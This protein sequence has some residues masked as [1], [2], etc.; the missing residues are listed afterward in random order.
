MRPLYKDATTHTACY[1]NGVIDKMYVKD[2]RR[3]H[4]HEYANTQLKVFGLQPHDY[5]RNDTARVSGMRKLRLTIINRKGRTRRLTNMDELE[6]AGVA[7]GY[8]VRVVSFE[9]LTI[10]QQLKIVSTETDVL[11]GMHGNGIMWLQ[12]LPP[13]SVIIELI[14]VWYSPYARLWGHTHLHSSMKN[15]MIFKRQGEFVAFPHNVT[16]VR[17]LLTKAR[18]TLRQP[19]PELKIDGDANPQLDFLYKGCSPHC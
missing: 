2:L 13:R 17:V 1:T 15:N 7:L 3:N 9:L 6:T 16:E 11:M 5:T 10:A 19:N 4:A 14:G 8:D 12:F 18:G